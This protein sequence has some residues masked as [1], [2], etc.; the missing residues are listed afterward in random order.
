MQS[1][2][3][4]PQHD[5]NIQSRVR[6]RYSREY[7]ALAAHGFEELCFYSE[8]L[9]TF[10]AV[11]QLPM[12]LLMLINREVLGGHGHFDAGGS[13]LL[14]QHRRPATIALPLGLGIKLYTGFTDGTVLISANF[15]SCLEPGDDRV[16]K[17]AATLPLDENWTLHQQR[18]EKIKRSGCH[19]VETLDFDRYVEMSRR[20][21]STSAC[22]QTG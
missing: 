11:R 3:Y 2:A 21:D 8:Q 6:R 14:M 4:V 16:V 10:S 18:V 12:T 9:G 17:H 20:E 5:R 7:E 15:D 13:Y 22:S 19:V 1:I